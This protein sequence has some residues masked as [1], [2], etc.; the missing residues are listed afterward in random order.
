MR[1]PRKVF[2]KPR[3]ACPEG[4][5][6]RWTHQARKSRLLTQPLPD[7][8]FRE[9]VLDAVDEYLVVLQPPVRVRSLLSRACSVARA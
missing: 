6:I 2:D 8:T 3:G 5:L 1:V 4:T 9:R 7:Y